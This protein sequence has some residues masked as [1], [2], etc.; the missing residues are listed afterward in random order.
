MAG[1]QLHA[2]K[3]G[4]SWDKPFIPLKELKL[5]SHKQP[6]WILVSNTDVIGVLDVINCLG[7][8][9]GADCCSEVKCL[10]FPESQHSLQI[11]QLQR[12][13]CRGKPDCPCK[14]G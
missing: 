2:D 12:G 14:L 9:Y 4:Q 13:D 5:I 7:F 10:F 1:W 8:T 11:S 6:G 3:M